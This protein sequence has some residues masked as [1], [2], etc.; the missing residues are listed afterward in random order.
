[1]NEK[2]LKKMEIKK[3][4]FENIEDNIFD[5][6]LYG[7]GEEK[8]NCGK[9]YIGYANQY[10]TGL[11]NIIKILLKKKIGKKITQKIEKEIEELI[12]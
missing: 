10:I 9:D 5:C 11:E 8:E 7:C 1:M 4:E 3:K 2:I 12:D 6:L